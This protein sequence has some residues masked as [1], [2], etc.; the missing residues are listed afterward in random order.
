MMHLK[1]IGMSAFII[2][3]FQRLKELDTDS[4]N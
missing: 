4:K 3:L 2:N 1:I